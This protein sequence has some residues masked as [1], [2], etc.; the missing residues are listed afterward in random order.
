LNEERLAAVQRLQAET[1][2]RVAAAREPAF[3]GARVSALLAE[4]EIALAS[5]RSNAQ[6]TKATLAAYWDGPPGI[7]LDPSWL[8][9]RA[10]G[11][12]LLPVENSADLALFEAERQSAGARLGLEEARA[13]QDPT[14]AGGVRH[15]AMGNDL[16][17]IATIAIPLPFNDDKSGNIARALAEREAAN[18]EYAAQRRNLQRE[19]TTLQ[20]RIAA[21]TTESDAIGRSAIPEAERA[22]G[23]IREGFDRGAFEYIDIIDAERNLNNAKT[24]RLDV[25]RNAHLDLARLNRLTGRYA[26][27]IS[28]QEIR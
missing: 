10:T 15:F 2:R 12:E 16:A 28:G 6:T 21:Q 19:I 1:E 20:A 17:L 3:A 7:Q 4:T 9:S 27:I 18:R 26:F 8:E 25:M 22:L 14:F 23:L 5:A 13:V 24:R 11:P